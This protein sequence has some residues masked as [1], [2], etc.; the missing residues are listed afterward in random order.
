MDDS[1]E[2]VTTKVNTMIREIV[3]TVSTKRRGT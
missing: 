3:D 2:V 1:Q